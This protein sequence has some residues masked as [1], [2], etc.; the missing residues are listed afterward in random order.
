MSKSLEDRLKTHSSAFDSLLS[1]I[2]ARYY[3][4]ENSENQWKAKKKSKDELKA[5]KKAK[6][7]PSNIEI[8]NSSASDILRERE[9]FAKPVVIPGSKG[10]GIAVQDDKEQQEEEEEEEEEAGY[11]SSELEE[12]EEEENFIKS[13]HEG[14]TMVFD[15]EGNEIE[16]QD[17]S[18]ISTL[19]STSTSSSN[20]SSSKKAKKLSD[21]EEKLKR[22][23]L[24]K[25]KEKLSMKI[26]LLK[27]KRK[28][29]GTKVPGAPQSREE[30]L[31][32]RRQ[33][34]ESKKRK[35][36]ED[37]KDEEEDDIDDEDQSSEDEEY[38]NEGGSM[39]FQNI[40]FEDGDRITSDLSS[41]RKKPTKKGPS[42]NDIRAHLQKL[43]KEKEKLSQMSDEE[44]A[45][46][47]EKAKW[48]KAMLNV[49]G[50]KLKD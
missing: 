13:D 19:V 15:D 9:K 17:E 31:E 27:E 22:E 1:L 2:P 38:V 35:H 32:Q 4:D 46:F 20:G 34:E 44:K 45:K 21:E 36:E 48:N 29:L 12:E 42:N 39:L 23:K 14:I 50:V 3:Y 33:K 7:D 26:S 41:L 8:E 43:Q 25:L 24:A 18:E 40:V 49:E 5:N 16:K 47:L 10:N 37:E 28:A 11:N 30:I 6:L